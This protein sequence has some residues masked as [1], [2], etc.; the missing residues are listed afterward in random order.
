M[1]KAL[2][3]GYR[4]K[5]FV[6]TKI[7]GRSNEGAASQNDQSLRRLQ[8]YHLDLLQ[9]HEIIRIND[10]DRIFASGCGAGS[11]KG[12]QITVSWLCRTQRSF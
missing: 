9:F 1:G 8:T 7:D 12:W 4:E 5:V 10:P 11:Q 6:M 2:R 3:D